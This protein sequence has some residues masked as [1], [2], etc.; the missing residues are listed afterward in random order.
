M[1]ADFNVYCA[2]CSCSLGGSCEIGSNDPRHLKLRRAR[3]A[4]RTYSRHTGSLYY[5]TEE[6]SED[7][8]E[9]RLHKMPWLQ[10]T[11]EA[12]I[13]EDTASVNSFDYDHSYDPDVIN[14][15]DLSWMDTVFALGISHLKPGPQTCV[16][17]RF[18][19]F[20]AIE[21]T[22]TRYLLCE[23]SYEDRVSMLFQATPPVQL[24]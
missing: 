22:V 18:R 11:A 23:C 14:P 10:E 24:R 7:E 2:I 16:M 9:E 1:V 5:E 4:R 20:L 8:K 17:P 21:L 19:N 3:V 6:E 13:D 15:E 12:D